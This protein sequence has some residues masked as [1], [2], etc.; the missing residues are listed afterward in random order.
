MYEYSEREMINMNTVEYLTVISIT[1]LKNSI[2]LI[3]SR[4]KLEYGVCKKHAQCYVMLW[5]SEHSSK[6]QMPL[7]TT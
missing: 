5:I 1:V 6:T 3:P 2:S 4:F 7:N